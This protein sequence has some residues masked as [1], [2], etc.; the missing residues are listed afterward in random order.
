MANTKIDSGFANSLKGNEGKGGYR[1][2]NAASLPCLTS[3]SVCHFFCGTGI[4][5]FKCQ[6]SCM[7]VCFAW[8]QKLRHSIFIWEAVSWGW[9]KSL[10]PFSYT[11]FNNSFNKLDLAFWATG[12]K[13]KELKTSK[14]YYG[15]AYLSNITASPSSWNVFQALSKKKRGFQKQSS[16]QTEFPFYF[17]KSCVYPYCIPLLPPPTK[18]KKEK[19]NFW[20]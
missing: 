11:D 2:C 15:C 14:N 3:L 9:G 20:A 17:E 7:P 6:K 16:Q 19:A 1:S 13:H 12:N 8:L 4:K 18:K 5:S 10:V